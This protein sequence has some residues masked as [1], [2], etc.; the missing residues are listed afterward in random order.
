M[1]GRKTLIALACLSRV[2]VA[3]AGTLTVLPTVDG[4]ATWLNSS[5]TNIK[6][7]RF[8]EAA[9][10]LLDPETRSALE[11]PLTGIPSGVVIVSATLSLWGIQLEDYIVVHGYAG[12]GSLE[13]SDFAL[14]NA[15]AWFDPSLGNSNV[16][17]VTSF[18]VLEYA[19]ASQ[20]G[21]FQ[22]QE[23]VSGKSTQFAGNDPANQDGKDLRPYLNIEY[24]T[25]SAPEPATLALLGLGL[26]GLGFARRKH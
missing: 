11:F 2:T 26:A 25:A 3:N 24:T 9:L 22:L 19:A 14:S 15:I 4:Y 6:H 12:N 16:I 18:I 10:P 21:G 1:K 23:M 17:D 5:W 13:S 7:E 20:Y 8:L